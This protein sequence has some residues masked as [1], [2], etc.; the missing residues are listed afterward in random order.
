MFCTLRHS[1]GINNTCVISVLHNIK[2]NF[3]VVLHY[4]PM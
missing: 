1:L 3:N 4:F 2:V